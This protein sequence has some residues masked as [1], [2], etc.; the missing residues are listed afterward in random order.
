MVCFV[1]ENVQILK[2]KKEKVHEPSQHFFSQ[3]LCLKLV[4]GFF[5]FLLLLLG[6]EI[7]MILNL[8]FKLV[9]LFI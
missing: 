1:F 9:S 8:I 2:K 7:K 6:F 3:V 5:F 4:F